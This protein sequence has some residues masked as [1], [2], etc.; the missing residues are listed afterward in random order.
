MRKTIAA[1]LL[2]AVLAGS[3][4]ACASGENSEP[5]VGTGPTAGTE[6][7]VG[8]GEA[9]EPAGRGI[10]VAYLPEEIGAVAQA[11]EAIAGSVGGTLA[12]LSAGGGWNLNA[13]AFVLLGFAAQNSALPAGVQTFLRESDLGARTIYPF[14][15]GQGN[16]EDA[17]F[18]AISDLEPGALLGSSALLLTEGADAESAA[19][20]AEGLSLAAGAAAPQAGGNNTVRTAAVTPG[21]SQTLYLWEEGNAPATTVYTEN[22]GGYFDDPDFR[23][24][25]TYSPV[26]AGTAV[27]GAVLICPGG[28]FQFR[29]DQPEGVDVAEALS[30]L[31]Y[32]SFVVDYRLRPYTQQEGALDLA[33]AVRFV[34]AHAQAY[35][36]DPSDIAVMGF[37]AGGI[38]SGEMLL[39]YDGAVDPT[40][41]DASYAPDALDRVSADAAACGMIYSFYGRLS[42][43]T[44]DVELLRSGD[45]PPT[46]Y[47]YGTRDPFYDQFLANADAAEA[48]GVAVERLQLDG[49]PHGFGA[50]G[51]WIPAYDAWLTEVFA[52]ND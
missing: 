30:A 48:A 37:S 17:V 51:G 52:A 25:L 40:A 19:A 22:N 5:T 9:A 45:L 15:L 42:V 16:A 27:K 39:H 38:L 29:S 11:A 7:T 2:L 24:Y 47:C 49:M 35:G 26:P 36:I 23:P 50:S 32:Q 1:L 43:G 3:L 4:T 21:Q 14:V 8:A 18:A 12:D 33:R 46:F 10:L 44:T 6:P 28:A 20:W 34:R 13:Y 31:G 41:L